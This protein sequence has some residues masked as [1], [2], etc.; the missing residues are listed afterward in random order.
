MQIGENSA[1]KNSDN[2]VS[3]LPYAEDYMKKHGLAAGKFT[4]I[5]NGIIDEEWENPLPLPEMH[6]NVFDNLHDEKKF[7]VGYFGGHALSNALNNLVET[8]AKI[9]DDSI[10]FVL[11][12]DGVEKGILIKRSKELELNNITFMKAIPKRAI[13][14][15]CKEFDCIYMGSMESPLYRFGLCLN[16]MFDSMMAGKPI[17]CAITTPKTYIE[18]YGCGIKV[19]S[20]DVAGCVSAINYIKNLSD[21]E[22][23]EINNNG[24]KL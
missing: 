2:V 6:Q 12:G 24:K 4:C 10:H 13:P 7:I 20:D 17:I 21:L 15:L 16:K 5:P 14:S 3:L 23:A 9:D 1:Y 22:K 11:V 8:A 18:E 19:N